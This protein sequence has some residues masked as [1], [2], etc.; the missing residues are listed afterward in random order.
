MNRR[1]A[2]KSVRLG[3]LLLLLL[4]L[5]A[6]GGNAAPMEEQ[7]KTLFAMDTWFSLT[8]YGES[9]GDALDAAERKVRRLESLFSVT[10]PDNE[11][12]ALNHSVG[13][14]VAASENMAQLLAFSLEMAKGTDGCFDPTIYPLLT[15]WGFTT[16]EYRVP[17][18]SE[19][20][21]LLTQTGYEKEKA[22]FVSSHKAMY[23]LQSG[24]FRR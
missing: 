17:G 5:T 18:Q 1:T 6:C 13:V 15:A 24:H 23:P 2:A 4:S 11:L 16:Q 8:A 7:D 21:Q 3:I 12:Y 14:A 20:D 10:D 9:A 19:I 22:F